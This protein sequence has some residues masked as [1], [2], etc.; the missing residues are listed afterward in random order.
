VRL[1]IAA[2]FAQSRGASSEHFL[3]AS[4]IVSEIA[5]AAH[6]IGIFRLVFNRPG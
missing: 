2:G 5:W 1:L 6:F 3:L 4:G